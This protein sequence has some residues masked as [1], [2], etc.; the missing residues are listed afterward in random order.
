MKTNNA[1]TLWSGP[2]TSGAVELFPNEIDFRLPD[3]SDITDNQAFTG[4][5]KHPPVWQ[6]RSGSYWNFPRWNVIPHYDDSY[7]G[8]LIFSNSW[9]AIGIA[10][11]CEHCDAYGIAE[12]EFY[13][14]ADETIEEIIKEYNFTR[15]TRKI[16]KMPGEETERP[17]TPADYK[18]KGE[19][20]AGAFVRWETVETPAPE[21]ENVW[22]ENPLFCEAYGFR[23]NGPNDRDE[24]KHGIYSR[25][26]NGESMDKLTR[27]TR[28]RLEISIY[29]QNQ[30]SDY[31]FPKWS[32]YLGD[33]YQVS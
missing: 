23:P 3:D 16:V 27:K 18:D 1:F 11:A 17:A 15:E 13:P 30:Y 6:S 22:M 4:A 12:D 9:G 24:H 19:L 26:L 29:C 8:L 7:G 32:D 21:G 5:V 20:P 10:R 28:E 31:P 2:T 33:R 14:E 25:D